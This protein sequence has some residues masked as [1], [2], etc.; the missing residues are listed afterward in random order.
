MPTRSSGGAH[1]P[2]GNA[3]GHLLFL[4]A[5]GEIFI[6]GEQRIHA[7]PMLAIDNAG[8]NGI[9]IDAVLD[10]IEAADCVRLMT[11]GFGGAINGNQ[12][13]APPAG[14][15]CHVDDLALAL[16]PDHGPG[17]GLHGEEVPATLMLNRRS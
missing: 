16:V 12:G 3:G 5:D 10:E 14:L 2:I 17:N 11:G 4:F 1:A 7:C 8:G 13:L 15:A 9:D 6:F